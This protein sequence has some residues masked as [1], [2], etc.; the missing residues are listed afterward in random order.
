[1]I[2]KICVNCKK[3][4]SVYNYRK[5]SKYCCKKCHYE[6][7]KILTQSIYVCDYCSEK[8]TAYKSM[9]KN[10]KHH[11]CCK[12]CSENYSKIREYNVTD[13]QKIK[14]SI[15]NTSFNIKKEFLIENYI[16]SDNSIKDV[17]LM[18]GCSEITIRKWL[19][20]YNLESKP[21]YIYLPNYNKYKE[22][23]IEEELKK[24]SLY[25]KKYYGEK[26]LICGYDKSVD[27]HH[28][29]PQKVG[30]KSIIKNLIVLCPNHHR[31][32]HIGLLSQEYLYEI[33]ETIIKT[34]SDTPSN[35]R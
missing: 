26:C 1:M 29:L 14:I 34:K 9:Q 16:N 12:K 7:S 20:K 33:I 21:A 6:H 8:F 18:V 30:G 13:Q 27:V 4:F 32:A 25:A 10:N 28:I 22:F 23:S 24:P 5:D 35:R 17:A 11:F 19:R 2:D 31:E 15:K 3:K